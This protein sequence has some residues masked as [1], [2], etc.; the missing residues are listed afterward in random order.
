MESEDKKLD[1]IMEKERQ[2]VLQNMKQTKDAE[3]VKRMQ[4]ANL[5]KDQIKENEMA[6][7]QEAKRIKNVN[8]YYSSLNY[9]ELIYLTSLCVSPRPRNEL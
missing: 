4:Y 1:E 2:K 3:Q 6:R 5:I 9:R 8:Y 7:V